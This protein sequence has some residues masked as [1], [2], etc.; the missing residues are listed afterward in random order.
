MSKI[1]WL[2]DKT[3]KREVVF[4]DLSW[5]RAYTSSLSQDTAG[6]AVEAEPAGIQCAVTSISGP[7]QIYSTAASDVLGVYI[8]GSKVHTPASGVS[9]NSNYNKHDAVEEV[10]VA[11][12]TPV[13]SVNTYVAVQAIGKTADSDGAILIKCGNSIVSIIGPLEREASYRRLALM[14]IPAANTVFKY[15]AYTDPPKLVNTNQTP[16]PSVSPEYIKWMA[17]SDIYFQMRENER[18]Q[19]AQATAGRIAQQYM[20]KER[21]YGGA[22]GGRVEPEDFS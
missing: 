20:K 1:I 12:A 8:Q 17:A 7:L 4:S 19:A 10:S 16:P 9:I 14:N 5:D 13:T 6:R 22:S 18:S 21:L 2:L 3:N 11:G 15:R